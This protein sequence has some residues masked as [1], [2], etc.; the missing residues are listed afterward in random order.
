[1]TLDQVFELAA[2]ARKLIPHPELVVIG[3]NSILGGMPAAQVPAQ[4]SMSIDLDAYLKRDPDRTGELAAMLGENSSYHLDKGVFLDVVSPRLLTAPDGWEARMN[5]V[6]RDGLTVWFLEPVD[7][8]ISKLVRGEARDLR[9]VKGGLAA[10][11]LTIAQIRVRLPRTP[12]LDGAEAAATARRLDEIEDW[13]AA[14]ATADPE[15][16]LGI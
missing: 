5:K 3:S 12:F 1:M 8:A 2:A 4:M 10:G 7:A 15:P 6:E 11:I 13:L 9:W 16:D 14:G